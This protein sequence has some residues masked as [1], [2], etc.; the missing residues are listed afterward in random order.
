MTVY[1]DLHRSARIMTVRD[2]TRSSMMIHDKARQSTTIYHYTRL[3]TAFLDDSCVSAT[4]LLSLYLANH[5][6]RST[7]APDSLQF[8]KTDCSGLQQPLSMLDYLHISM[9]SHN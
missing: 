9:T 3:I 8:F 2:D 1:A 5:P 4:I 6:R 7:T